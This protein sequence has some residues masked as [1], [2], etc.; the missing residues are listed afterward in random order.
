[1]SQAGFTKLP[2]P[3]ALHG[4]FIQQ[5][6][7][8][9]RTGKAFRLPNPPGDRSDRFDLFV[10]SSVGRSVGQAVDWSVRRR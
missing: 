10:S 3:L 2:S 4:D 9:R 6:E 8:L 5:V 7:S 1:M